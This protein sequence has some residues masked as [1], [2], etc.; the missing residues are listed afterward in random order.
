[1]AIFPTVA[2]GGTSGVSW[3]HMASWNIHTI[4]LAH[5]TPW[6]ATYGIFPA[7]RPFPWQGVHSYLYFPALSH[8]MLPFGEAC[9]LY[10]RDSRL[11]R[12]KT[13]LYIASYKDIGVFFYPCTALFRNHS[14]NPSWANRGG[15]SSR[16][17]IDTS[18]S[19]SLFSRPCEKRRFAQ[20]KSHSAHDG[21][22]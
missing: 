11:D 1:M 22:K 2:S 17:V 18:S 13:G 14:V 20:F 4:C 21:I 12:E 16:N 7:F 8:E 15:D 10:V 6:I 19:N 5:G 3:K 9:P